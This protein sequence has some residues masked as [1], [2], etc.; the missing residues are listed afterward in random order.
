MSRYV[1]VI[2]WKRGERVA[3]RRLSRVGR[4]SVLPLAI[5]SPDQ[6]NAREETATKPSLSAAEAFVQEVIAAWGTAP[7]YL[8]AATLPIGTSGN[9]PILRIAAAARKKSVALIPATR[10]GAPPA[11][12][13]AVDSIATTDGLGVGLRVDLQELTNASS[14]IRRWF[15]PIGETDLMPDFA[16]GVTTVAA[17]GS[18]VDHA[19][20]TLHKAAAWRTITVIGS[21]MPGNFMGYAAGTHLV[22]REEWRLFRRL[23]RVVSYPL[24]YGDYTTV[25]PNAPPPGIAWG[26]PINVR[27]TLEADFLICRG[28]KTTG[29][30]AV[31]MD[32]QLVGHARTIRAYPNRQPIPHC[33][34]DGKIDR[35][36]SS[37]DDPGNL[38]TW[39][40][41]GVNRHIE[42]VR[43]Q[44]P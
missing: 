14:W 29:P 28:V 1:P 32:I 31:D 10:I 35:I 41:I 13:T 37:T 12:Q 27:Y 16:D 38:E 6:Y 23:S 43:T 34:A 7:F 11:Y 4:I 22:R 9:H 8:D 26:F 2:R 39:V 17:L 18:S 44:L 25:S 21:S 15:R 20:Q 33:W 40:Q 36:A 42:L 24:D 5:I 19:F 30:G 3:L